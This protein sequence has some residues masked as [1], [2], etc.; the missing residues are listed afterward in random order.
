MPSGRRYVPLSRTNYYSSS[1]IPSAIRWLNVV[2]ILNDY[3]IISNLIINMNYNKMFLL[4]MLVFLFLTNV[5]WSVVSD[6]WLVSFWFLC[7]ELHVRTGLAANELLFLGSMK[8]SKSELTAPY[9]QTNHEHLSVSGIQCNPWTF[10]FTTFDFS[11][12]E[13]GGNTKFFEDCH[14]RAFFAHSWESQ[15]VSCGRCMNAH[16]VCF[17]PLIMN[18]W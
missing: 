4:L 6:I 12:W 15:A 7:M 16:I 1:F 17:T 13:S 11:L 9:K 5:Y 18:L 10:D 2:V 14:L 8:L 3:Y